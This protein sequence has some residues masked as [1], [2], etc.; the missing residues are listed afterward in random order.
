MTRSLIA[1]LFFLASVG[2][3]GP[4]T[5][6]LF[7]QRDACLDGSSHCSGAAS[8]SMTLGTDT[9]SW[10]GNTAVANYGILHVATDLTNYS[11]TNGTVLSYGN[12]TFVDYLTINDPAKTGQTGT[13]NLSYFIDGAVGRTGDASAF[14]QVV[15]RVCSVTCPGVVPPADNYVADF[16]PSGA[17]TVYNQTVHIVQPFSFVYGTQFELYFGMQATAGTIIDQNGLGYQD[18]P[19]TGSGSGFAN[20]ADTLIVNGLD[21][22]DPNAQFSALSGT[23]FTAQGVAPEPATVVLCGAP[24]VFLF[25]ARRLRRIVR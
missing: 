17:F 4:I 5:T 3:G 20:F 23:T 21:T 12:V 1:G 2:W 11:V 6:S 14:L 8:G 15:A 19:A 10:T 24:L 16:N 25:F 9:M 7:E 13:L 22:G 18:L